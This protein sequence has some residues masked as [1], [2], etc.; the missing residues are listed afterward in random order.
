[1]SERIKN[2]RQAIKPRWLDLY[3]LESAKRKG[4]DRPKQFLEV[5]EDS[6]KI[7]LDIEFSNIKQ[8]TLTEVIASRRSLREYRD[9]FL[10][11]EELSYLLWETC[12]VDSFRENAVFRTIPTAGATNSMETY[13]YVNKVE[14]LKAGIYLYLQDTHQL[15]LIKREKNLEDI[16]NDS[17]LKQLRNAQAV[18]FFTT[19]PARTEY[20]Y[21]FCAHKMIAIESGHAC[22]N[23]SLAAEVIDAGVCAI[24]AYDQEK[25]DK[26]LN[27][28]GE[29]HFTMYCATVGKKK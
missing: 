25:V 17:L 10:T 24:C 3:T 2:N 9:T 8:K 19:I 23:L 5:P 13:V 1:M 20:K 22:Q 6:L 21:D 16:V 7:P 26:V 4:L 27:I 15:A 28:D 29:E 14:K 18:F 12:R 11:F